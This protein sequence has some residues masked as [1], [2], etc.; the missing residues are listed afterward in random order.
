MGGTVNTTRKRRRGAAIAGVTAVIVA[1]FGVS[2][3][4]AASQ[5]EKPKATEVGVSA[6]EV[7]IAVI[8]DVDEPVAPGLFKGAV[9]G[10]KA[11]A[12]YLNSKAGGGGIAGRKLVVDFYDSKLN[13]TET[14][15]ATI[16]A[17]ENDLAMVGT[18][19]L[20]LSSVDDMV[21]CK[22]QSGK[23]VGL[24]DLGAVVA[25]IPQ[26]CAPISFPAIGSA[27]DCS[28]M[29][30][31]PQTY[32]GNQGPSKWLLSQHKGGLHGPMIVSNDTKDANRGGTIL[33][34][35]AQAAGIKADQGTTV[36]KSA[37]D[38]Q[39]ALTEVVQKMKADGSNY[40]LMTSTPDQ[41]LALRQEATL[42][43]LDTSKIVWDTVSVYGNPV[44]TQNASAFE[45]EYQALNFLPFEETSVNKTLAAYV[46]Y[47]K[48]VGG[49][50][51]QYS[52]YSFEATMAFAEAAKAAVAAK[53]VNGLT[54]S[55]FIDGVKSLTDFDAGGMAGTHSFKTGKTTACF[56]EV[57][58]RSGKWVR[59]YPTK[60][61]TFDC[62]PQNSVAIK[63]DLLGS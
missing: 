45:G 24:P 20:F 7:H 23:A 30:Q 57:Q 12:A 49:H 37:R 29:T 34:L 4:P 25:G 39:S 43:G 60:K 44:V 56:V 19:A 8:A 5:T 52:A 16:T 47:V 59:V 15:N 54:R 2:A 9:D 32:N 6:S 31:T 41:A 26:A 53:G 42:Q 27:Y 61:G 11:G 55:S 3:G 17:C 40:T 14:R 51:D 21:N 58:F 10:V 50:P 28:T 36:A 33:A 48:K 18:S 38:P 1:M 13:P 63:A 46:K 22:D 62:K 35:A